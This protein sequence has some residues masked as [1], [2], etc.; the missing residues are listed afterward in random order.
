MNQV[1][2]TKEEQKQLSAGLAD[3]LEDRN[4][5]YNGFLYQWR[6]NLTFDHTPEEREELYYELWKMVSLNARSQYR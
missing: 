1:Y 3:R 4:K 5:H 6:E 2:M